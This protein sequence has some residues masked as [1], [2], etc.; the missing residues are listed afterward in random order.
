MDRNERWLT[1][2]PGF[3][4]DYFSLR[5]QPVVQPEVQTGYSPANALL[6]AE[7]S[8]WVYNADKEDERIHPAE[9]P[10]HNPYLHKAKLEEVQ[11]FALDTAQASLVRTLDKSCHFLVFRGT[12]KMQDWMANLSAQAKR[13]GEHGMVHQGFMESFTP[14]WEQLE[15][16][17][18]KID[19]PIFYTGHSLG[20]THATLAASLR[21]PLALYTYG[22]PRVGDSEFVQSLEHTPIYRVVNGQDIVPTLPVAG[23]PLHYVHAGELI[24]F[25]RSLR[26]KLYRLLV[27][28][29]Y[30][31][32]KKKFVT[33]IFPKMENPFAPPPFLLDHAPYFYVR[34][35]IYK[36]LDSAEEGEFDEMA[37][38]GFTL[39]E[40]K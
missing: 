26:W 36:Y 8:R 19:T 33:E 39:L 15:P 10:H 6:L 27:N 38:E 11:L 16:V 34:R 3:S 7:L 12:S 32:R 28:L 35:L 9:I 24:R 30:A 4:Q 37:E 2:I 14:I 31:F 40:S 17:L 25:G 18:E 5:N 29:R 22:S 13:W 23:K 21:P 1:L 20:A